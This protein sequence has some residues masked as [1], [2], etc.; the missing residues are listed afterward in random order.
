MNVDP[1]Y[2]PADFLQL[3]RIGSVSNS[4][5]AS[6]LYHSRLKGWFMKY[7]MKQRWFSIRE[8]VGIQDE[9]GREAFRING[10]AFS[11]GQK[12]SFFD[13]HNNE[14]A[15]VSRKISPAGPAFEIYHGDDLQAVVPQNLSTSM[16]C[17]LATDAPAPDDLH[18]EGNFTARE[19][20]FTREGRPVGRVSKSLYQSRETYQ[21][22]V[23]R[24]EED[25]LLLAS[26][27]VIDLCCQ[28]SAV[29]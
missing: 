8:Q 3:M 24:G 29:E 25:I 5:R 27:A 28:N 10:R 4:G 22:E 14:L 23:G 17:K 2:P 7:R 26:A 13:H 11:L 18:A 19:Y 16:R 12:L 20:T 9:T 1:R 21:V 6:T 15:F